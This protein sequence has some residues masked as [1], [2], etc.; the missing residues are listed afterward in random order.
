[1]IIGALL[2]PHPTGLLPFTDSGEFWPV[3]SSKGT[4]NKCSVPASI[5]PKYRTTGCQCLQS[6]HSLVTQMSYLRHGHH[7]WEQLPSQS[8]ARHTWAVDSHSYTKGV[9]RMLQ[10][11]PPPKISF[12]RS[13]KFHMNIFFAFKIGFCLLYLQKC[14][15]RARKYSK[16]WTWL[17]AVEDSIT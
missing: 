7:G 12:H 3:P 2:I 17:E 11:P 10:K 14:I 13:S 8:H 6:N 16:P 5:L 1:M 15:S 4:F 9:W